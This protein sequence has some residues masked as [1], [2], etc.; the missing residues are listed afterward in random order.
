MWRGCGWRAHDFERRPFHGIGVST[1]FGRNRVA[2]ACNERRDALS[3]L[4]TAINPTLH[5]NILG[6]NR[7][8]VHFQPLFYFL[9]PR[10]NRQ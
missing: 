7:S 3:W 9:L 6:S 2:T 4:R 1:L 10:E 8:T 5:N